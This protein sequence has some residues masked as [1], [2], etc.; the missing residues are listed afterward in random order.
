MGHPWK[1]I[2]AP[3]SLVIA[4][5]IDS[6]ESRIVDFIHAEASLQQGDVNLMSRRTELQTNLPVLTEYIAGKDACDR[7]C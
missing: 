4:P 5:L 3:C 2:L 6:P 7:T 1:T